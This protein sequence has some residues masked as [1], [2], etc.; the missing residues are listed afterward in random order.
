[1]VGEQQPDVVGKVVGMPPD[2]KKR[3]GPTG[4]G[5]GAGSFGLGLWLVWLNG[6][7]TGKVVRAGT[8]G[9]AFLRAV[10]VMGGGDWWRGLEGDTVALGVTLVEEVGG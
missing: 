7:V 5:A 4:V 8:G 1:M 10:E 3:K 9:E 6:Q 2:K